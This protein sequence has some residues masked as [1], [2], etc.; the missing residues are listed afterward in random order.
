MKNT[1][2]DAA[3]ILLCIVVAFVSVIMIVIMANDEDFQRCI[4][5][6]INQWMCLEYIG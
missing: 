2:R 5:Q 4:F 3:I 6:G 1:L